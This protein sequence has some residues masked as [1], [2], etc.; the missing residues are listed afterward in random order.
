[1]QEGPK[2]QFSAVKAVKNAGVL[3]ALP[4]L[5][6]AGLACVPFSGVGV[7]SRRHPMGHKLICLQWKL[8]TFFGARIVAILIMP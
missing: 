3:V 4:A 6:E 7:D 2:P 5:L 8:L 1:M